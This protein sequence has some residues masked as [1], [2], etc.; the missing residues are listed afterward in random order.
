MKKILILGANNSQ[1]SLI[2]AAKEEG[3][4]V[5]A[6][7]YAPDN[8]GIPLVDNHYEVS[9]L[10]V[11]AVLNVARQEKIDGVI[12]NTDPAMPIVS[13]VAEQLG[14]VGNSRESVDV[15]ISKDSFRELQE[16][17]GL[18]CPKHV[19]SDDYSVIEKAV[20]N[21]EYPIIVKPD[22]SSGSKGTTKIYRNQAERLKEAF[23]VCKNLSLD[24]SVTVEEYVEMPSLDAIEGDL[25]VSGNEI[26]WDG[27][28]T[29][30]RSVLAPMLPMTKI[31]PADI[32]DE[33]LSI[34]KRDVTK[35]FKEAGVR[36]GEYNI[37]MYFT[38]QGELFIIE[39]NPRQGGNRIPQLLKQQ[40]GIDYDRLLVTTAVGDNTYLDSIRNGTHVNNYLS[41]HIV[42]SNYNGVLEK[43]EFKPEIMPYVIA[44][45]FIKKTGEKVNKRDNSSDCIAYVT[46]KF[47]DR[48]IQ[49]SYMDR[50]EKLIY[51]VV[52]D[53]EIPIANCSL[54]CQ[55]VYDFMT[56]DGYDFFVPKLERVP[57]TVEGYAEQLATFCT[58]A[59]D[60]DDKYQIKGMV[61]GY[62]QNLK[63]PGYA[64]I[65]E[66][67]VNSEY[68]REGLGEKLMTRFIAHCE[69][70]GLT[71][72]WLH[73]YADNIPAQKLYQ[74]L[75]FAIDK[76]Y[77]NGD[78]LAM[79]L[80]FNEA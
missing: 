46:L 4:Y 57:R 15:F 31:F 13:Y 48:T 23:E 3:Y 54:P 19:K 64:L 33:E 74:K 18:Y 5:I 30:P 2:K 75:G 73:V 12:G 80:T 72:V 39:N 55:L 61:A 50:I 65:A 34:V 16:R 44:T 63:R 37:E 21:F 78:Q 76:P 53:R 24:G 32:S 70:I 56:G 27:L 20:L 11:E 17:A 26:I 7:D 68:R 58:I 36:H 67:Y 9:Y 66:V 41:Q 6:C 38:P 60:I 29:N 22:L 51:P 47:P 45:E 25:F 62:T 8:P 40:T 1:V 14:L 10:D 69:S 49:L 59:Y 42:F 77:C 28:F 71:G 35:M 52:K 79:N 43:V